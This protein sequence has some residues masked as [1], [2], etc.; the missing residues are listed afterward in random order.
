MNY[1]LITLALLNMIFPTNLYLLLVRNKINNKKFPTS[2][3]GTYSIWYNVAKAT[4]RHLEHIFT[5]WT[6]L[7]C[8]SL[9]G[10][11]WYSDNI[12]ELGM[13]SIALIALAIVGMFP[14]SVSKD[15]TKVHC[16]AAKICA[17][18]A[19]VWLFLKGIYIPTLILLI[20]G[21]IWSRCFQKKYETLIMEY[22]AFMSADIGVI[23]CGLKALGV[24]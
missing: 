13:S 21:L 3:S 6:N 19:I 12:W 16:I 11:I 10:L 15:V 24:L 8:V 5:S 22:M 23:I 7:E 18:D 14:T 20:G 4:K 2:Y 1:F 17:L 9:A